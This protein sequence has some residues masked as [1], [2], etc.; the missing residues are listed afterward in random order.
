MH[1]VKNFTAQA[2]CKL[3]VFRYDRHALRMDGA[4]VRVFKQSD[5]VCFSGFVKREERSRLEAQVRAK[6]VRDLAHD[7]VK[8]ESGNKK[9]G[10]LLVLANFAQ[11]DGSRTIATRLC[12]AHCRG[13]FLCRS[14]GN[15]ARLLAR[16]LLCAHFCLRTASTD[17]WFVALLYKA[18]GIFF[19]CMCQNEGIRGCSVH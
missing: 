14:H 11:R 4:Q 13:R 15:F 16:G 3:H 18:R 9:L 10:R 7:A 2:S 12:A 17:F 19:F 6:V 1:L 5:K 8:G